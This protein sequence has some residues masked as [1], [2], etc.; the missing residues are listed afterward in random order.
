MLWIL[1][2]SKYAHLNIWSESIW[3][4]YSVRLNIRD[5]EVSFYKIKLI[6]F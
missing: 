4:N 3:I 2:E 5:Q 6:N 1:K